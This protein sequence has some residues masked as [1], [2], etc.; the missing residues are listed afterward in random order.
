[1]L[2]Q[3]ATFVFISPLQTK[4]YRRACKSDQPRSFLRNYCIIPDP[5]LKKRRRMRVTVNF[6]EKPK[7]NMTEYLHDPKQEC[8]LKKIQTILKQHQEYQASCSGGRQWKLKAKKWC[9]LQQLE[10]KI[11]K[12]KEVSSYLWIRVAFVT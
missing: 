9:C 7:Q 8:I 5:S 4:C 3:V 11:G 6:T 10:N 12:V 2:W 1:M